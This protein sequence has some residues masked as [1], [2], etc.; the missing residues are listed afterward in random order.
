MRPETTSF[1][2]VVNELAANDDPESSSWRQVYPRMV[3]GH[4]NPP[5]QAA[6][7]FAQQP[8]DVYRWSNGTVTL[9]TDYNWEP[10]V[11]V[12]ENNTPYANGTVYGPRNYTQ[13]SYY[14]AA[15]VFYCNH[16]DRFLA[17]VG[18]AG[19]R[20]I[21]NETDVIYSWQPLTF[22]HNDNIS[23]INFAGDQE[24]VICRSASWIDQLLPKAYRCNNHSGPTQGSLAGLLPLII[25]L[26]A[27]SCNRSELRN[28]LTQD[29]AWRNRNWR[30]HQR[31]S[32]RKS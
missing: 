6:G 23:Y 21:N 27:F 25:A 30:P 17:T 12:D 1:L 28:V 31:R 15:T 22:F 13:P 32:G 8:G 19:T 26:I 24:L 2:F 5:Q 29:R 10:R 4:W 3:N 16:F 9:A 7:F 20:D 14:R 18:D 11:V